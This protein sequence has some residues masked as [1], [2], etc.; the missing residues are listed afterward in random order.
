MS[1]NSQGKQ[2]TL[3]KRNAETDVFIDAT[4]RSWGGLVGCWHRLFAKRSLTE[5]GLFLAYSGMKIPLSIS[6]K[7]SVSHNVNKQNF[8]FCLI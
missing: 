5:S 6:K 4:P 7:L 1:K 3:A 8:L 2:L